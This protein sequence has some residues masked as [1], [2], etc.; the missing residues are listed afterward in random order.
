MIM[1][2]KQL[3]TS[4]IKDLIHIPRNTHFLICSG[5]WELPN[6]AVSPIS[7]G[8]CLINS[9]VEGYA[10][11]E[12]ANVNSLATRPQLKRR[13]LE[14]ECPAHFPP[15]PRNY[16]VGGVPY[17]WLMTAPQKPAA[18]LSSCEKYP[19]GSNCYIQRL[20]V[21]CRCIAEK[22]VCNR[23]SIPQ[24]EIKYLPVPTRSSN[25]SNIT[26]SENKSLLSSLF[27]EE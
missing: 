17:D 12:L 25:R 16:T 27:S 11:K 15:S 21:T 10:N 2:V 26:S 9:F 24:T 8:L 20:C 1:S 14:G 23:F 13:V 3:I 5:R 6:I 7:C 4:A 18:S 22:S 19:A